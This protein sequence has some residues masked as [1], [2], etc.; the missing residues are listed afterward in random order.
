MKK[1]VFIILGLY[2]SFGM[3]FAQDTE[4]EKPKDRPIRAPFESGI[5][6]DNQTTVVPSK[7]TLEMHIQHRFGLIKS[8]GASDLWGIYAPSANTRMGL[9][10]SITDDIMLG[11][12]ITRK[13]MYNEFQAKWTFLK[14]TRKNTIPITL[15]VYGNMAINGQ[16]DDVFGDDYAFA[17]RMSYFGQF[18]AGRKFNEWFSL[19]LN[20]SFTHFN[21]VIST[22]ANITGYEHDVIGLGGHMR[23][24]FSPQSSILIMY[25]TPLNIQSMHENTNVMNAWKSNFGIAYEVA[26]STHAFQ[27]FISTAD[28]IVPQDIY[29]Y[30]EADLSETEFRFGFNIT[31]LWNF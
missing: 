13:N 18:I 14:Q 29:M 7:K 5:L 26:T 15:T 22:E 23:F 27:I 20:A 24:K 21:S 19:E 10:Y 8:S 30:N 28:G 12:G 1:I 16:S 6:I 3:A 17:D 4:T 25:T 9:N 11:Y 31:R 2:M